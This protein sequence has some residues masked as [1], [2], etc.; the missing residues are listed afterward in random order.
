MCALRSYDAI[1]IGAGVAGLAAAR[2]LADAGFSVLILEARDRIGGR[3]LT[4]KASGSRVELGAEFVHGTPAEVL[5][6]VQAARLSL[7]EIPDE[8]YRARTGGLTPICD[9]WSTVG[10]LCKQLGQSVRGKRKDLSLL[11][12]LRKTRMS[13]GQRELL[14]NFV[15]GFDAGDPAK[16]SVQWLAEGADELKSSY[17]QF[18]LSDGY[19][20]IVAW[21]ATSL[22]PDRVEIRL[23]TIATELEWKRHDARIWVTNPA[24]SRLG[25]FIARAVIVALPHAVL[26]AGELRIRPVDPRKLKAIRELEI[27]HIFKLVLHFRENF[28]CKNEFIS[29]RVKSAKNDSVAPVFIHSQHEDVPVWWTQAPSTAPVLTAWAGGP[30][31]QALLKE[32]YQSRI[33]KSLHSLSRVFTIPR[34]EIDESLDS[35]TS[36][37]WTADPF[38]RGA[39]TYVRAGALDAAR[40]LAEPVR[41]TLFF[42]GEAT[43]A[44]GM[45]TV[46]AALSTGMRAGKECIRAL[47]RFRR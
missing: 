39:Y 26:K 35:C 3:I 19:G 38:S 7:V 28:W 29:K 6:V 1:V 23:N 21:L 32:S 4:V 42:A 25:P 22:N 36:H 44:D 45:G 9:F 41:Q 8:H 27:G 47:S 13:A 17:K 12:S 15:E 18:R 20:D 33:E 2:Q 16:I 24:G 43:D 34:K 46:A 30:K 10:R 5:K 14:L 40:A 37:D 31:A 11:D